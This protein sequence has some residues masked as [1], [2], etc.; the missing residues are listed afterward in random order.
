MAP[1]KHAFT[2]ASLSMQIMCASCHGGLK[3]LSTWLLL[4]VVFSKALSS[5]IAKPASGNVSHSVMKRGGIGPPS[6]IQPIDGCCMQGVKGLLQQ[7]GFTVYN[8]TLPFHSPTNPW[9]LADGK[10]DCQT[11]VDTWKK[12]SPMP[13]VQAVAT[14]MQCLCCTVNECAL[15]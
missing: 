7:A 12:V 10:V 11:Y 1:M 4:Y 9:N 13:L 15:L 2:N 14:C 8:P 6:G 5:S 3:R